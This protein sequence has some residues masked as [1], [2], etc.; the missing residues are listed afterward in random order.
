[1]G[2]CPRVG[3]GGGEAG[4]RRRWGV[5]GVALR[6]REFPLLKSV[7]FAPP[8]SV[9]DRR[10]VNGWYARDK[11]EGGHT[12]CRGRVLEVGSWGV[13]V[14]VEMGRLTTGVGGLPM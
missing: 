1:M 7:A 11:E 5:L 14:E 4:I 8:I 3:W 13:A 12:G 10:P 9:L 6:S 2:S